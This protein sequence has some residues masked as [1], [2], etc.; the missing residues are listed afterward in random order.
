M[1]R[2]GCWSW[3]LL[4]REPKAS[5]G[6]GGS[7]QDDGQHNSQGRDDAQ[8]LCLEIWGLEVELCQEKAQKQV[9]PQDGDS[10]KM[11]LQ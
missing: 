7:W 2:G 1:G 6:E 10:C 11:Q 8:S 3:I 9:D 5:R 4:S